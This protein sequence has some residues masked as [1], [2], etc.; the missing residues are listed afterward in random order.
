VTLVA[1]RKRLVLDHRGSVH[2]TADEREFFSRH[3]GEPE[4]FDAIAAAARDA[5]AVRD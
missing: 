5:D 3:D 4:E 1:S 2:R